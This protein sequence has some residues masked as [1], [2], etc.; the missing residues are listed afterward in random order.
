MSVLRQLL[1]TWTLAIVF[2]A[3]SGCSASPQLGDGKP[4]PEQESDTRTAEVEQ[5]TAAQ[6]DPETAARLERVRQSLQQGRD[7]NETDADGRS[8]L[9]MAAFD[10]HTAVVALLLE[11]GADANLRDGAGRTALMFASSGPFPTTVEFLLQHG[12]QVN[13]STSA[14]GWTA[15]MWAG[16][17]G[18]QP[19]VEILLRHGADA[20]AADQDGERAIDHARIREQPHIVALL[21]SVLP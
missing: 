8:S 7:V 9:M 4:D 14:E 20:G 3:L 21:E 19:V 5:I 13:L 6:P 18:H 11:H 1:A 16:G 2:V 10:G 12:A 15:L 17:E